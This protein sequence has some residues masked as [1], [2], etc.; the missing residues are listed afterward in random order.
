MAAGN[1]TR[2]GPG[3][4]TR[5]MVVARLAAETKHALRTTEFYAYVATIIGVLIAGAAIKGAGTDEFRGDEVWLFVTILTVG[6]MISRGL[7][8]AGSSAP[9][10]QDTPPGRD[11]VADGDR[12]R[13]DRFETTRS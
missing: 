13:S 12:T 2:S 6:Y 5:P 4:A 7:A 1:M 9:F 3:G 11:D 8:K 10:G